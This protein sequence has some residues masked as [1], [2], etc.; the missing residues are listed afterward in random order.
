M[1]DATESLACG[2]RVTTRRDFLGRV[3]GTIV[4]RDGACPR[5]D[6]QPGAQVVMPGRDNAG[7]PPART[8]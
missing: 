3:V 2:C 1:S 5:G 7:P 4:E 8:L 6:H